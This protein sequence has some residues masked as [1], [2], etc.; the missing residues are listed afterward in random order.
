MD[1]RRLPFYATISLEVGTVRLDI[2]QTA[3][4]HRR[5][6]GAADLCEEPPLIARV[7]P[8]RMAF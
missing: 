1:R 6:G 5:Y 3:S 7:P 4:F 8:I 2:D